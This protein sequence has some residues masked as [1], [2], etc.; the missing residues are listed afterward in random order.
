[1]PPHGD[2]A[3]FYAN[4]AVDELI[5]KAMRETE[6]AIRDNYYKQAQIILH[7]DAV[8]LPLHAL[9]QIVAKR[10]N[11]EG[12]SILPIEIVLVKDAVIK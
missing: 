7:E 10:S 6:P 8:W 5:Q 1:M 4:P 11:V 2:N 3:S 9:Q 12:I